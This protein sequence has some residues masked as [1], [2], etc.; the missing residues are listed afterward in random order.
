MRRYTIIMIAAAL[1]FLLPLVVF[2]QFVVDTFYSAEY[3]EL[4]SLLPWYGIYLIGMAI[5]IVFT[6]FLIS[7]RQDRTYFLI[8]ISSAV[9]TVICAFLTI[10]RLGVLGAVI[11]LCVPHSVGCICYALFSLKYLR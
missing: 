2:P 6:Q 8:Y 1:P 5:G 11:S 3:S 4:G 9:A 10:P 7:M